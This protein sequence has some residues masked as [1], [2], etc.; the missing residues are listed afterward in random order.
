MTDIAPPVAA[1][2]SHS[3]T[4]HGMTRSDPYNWLRADNWR[5]VMA[6]PNVLPGDIRDYLEAENAWY[7]TG[8]GK[9]TEALREK[10]YSEIRGRIK[11]DDSSVPSPDGP[12]AYAS[13]TREGDQYPLIVRTPRDG[14]DENVLLDCNVE[15]GEGYFG[16]GGAE[17]SPCHTMVAW[18]ADRNGSEYYTIFVR[19]LDTGK[20]RDERIEKSGSG[21]VWANDSSR[22]YYVEL[23]ENHRPFRVREHVLG[24]SQAD[25]PIVYEEKDAGFFVGVGMTQSRRYITIS[26]HDHQTSEVWLIDA[27]KGGTPFCVEKRHE[28]TEYSVE[29]RDGT[30]Y[31]LTNDDGAEDFKIVTAPVSAPGVSNWSDLVPHEAGRLILDVEVITNHLIRL[32]RKDG[33]PRIVVRDLRDGG[34]QTVSFPEEAYSL[35]LVSGYEFDTSTIRFSYSSPTTPAQIFDLDLASGER[36]LRKQQE[37]P[38][39]HDPELYETRRLFAKA[40]DGEEVP[41]TLLYR[42]GLA[43]DGSAPALLYGYGAYGHSIPAGFSVSVLSLVDRGFV[44]A[45]AHIR[46]G[47]DK[48]YRWYKDGRAAHKPNTFSDFIAAAEMLIEKGYSS[49]GRIVAEGGSAGGMLMGAI[50]NMRPELWAGVMAIVPFVDVLNTMLDDTLPLTPPEWPEWGN[51]ITS[52]DDYRRIAAYSPYDNV[53]AKPYPPILV[54]AGLTDPRVTYWEPAKWVAKLR[55]TKTDENALYLRTNMDAGHGGA[56]GRFER[57]KETAITYAFALKCAQLA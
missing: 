29:E 9:P 7:E 16:F 48:G 46:G 32:E 30:L 27:E 22:F 15:A 21:A 52:E 51:P 36:V 20:D 31:I 24:T 14:G 44:Y 12:F 34:E 35:G 11:E 49:K 39:G 23:D 5:E 53:E 55:A 10:I 28:N 45:I 4:R 37:V 18:A 26:A 43:L 6:D 57:I 42:K 50:A 56:S 54:L 13:R 41:V 3:D 19:D 47:M 8:F 38:S 33:L 40:P 2:R 1:Q 17:H 25:D